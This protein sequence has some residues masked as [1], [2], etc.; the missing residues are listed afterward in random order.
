MKKIFLSLFLSV[1]SISSAFSFTVEDFA[2]SFHL[3]NTPNCGPSCV[4]LSAHDQQIGSMRAAPNKQ[5]TIYFF[6]A[7]GQH[8]ISLKLEKIY[9]QA[10]ALRLSI[11]DHKNQRLGRVMISRN[12][13]SRQLM[14]FEIY[15]N[16]NK[17]PLMTGV[18]NLFG[19]KHT[20]Y[21]GNTYHVLA[22]ITRPLFTY[23]RDSDIK[24]I[25]KPTVLTQIDPNVFAAVVAFYC[26]EKYPLTIA[27]KDEIDIPVGPSPSSTLDNLEEKLKQVFAERGFTR[28]ELKSLPQ[29]QLQAAA[30]LISERY[31]QVYDDSNLGDEEKIVQFINFGCD[32]IRSNS[33]EPAQEKAIFQFLAHRVIDIRLDAMFTDKSSS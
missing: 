7:K 12:H 13:K 27:D 32:L 21:L 19:T 10:A 6:D 23:S 25:D 20:I 18:S 24:I 3:T 8:Q 9:Y 15:G 17:N 1:F 5:G 11:L 30:D 4:H 26:S 14:R 33:L 16:D 2:D 28:D 31:H 29:S 22:E